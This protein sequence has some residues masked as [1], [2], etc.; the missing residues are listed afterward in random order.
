MVNKLIKMGKRKKMKRTDALIETC[1]IQD[2]PQIS[3]YIL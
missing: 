1:F 3:G 2:A